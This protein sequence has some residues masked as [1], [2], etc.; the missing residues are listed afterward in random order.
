[1]AHVHSVVRAGFRYAVPLGPCRGWGRPEA[2]HLLEGLIE[3]A[4]REMKIDPIAL[5]RRNLVAPG[6]MPYRTASGQ[7]MDCG[8][9][10][11]M[12]ER[13]LE[14]A[15]WDG[16]PKRR[17]ESERRGLR[18]GIGLAMHCGYSGLQAERMELRVDPNGSVS[19][20]VGT[21]STGQGH[22]TMYAQMVCEWLG[23]PL[24]SVRVF[25][26]DTDRVLFGR[27]TYAERSAIVGGSALKGAADEVIRK[28][29]RLAAWML[30]ANDADIEFKHGE[31]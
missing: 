6:A 24:E 8:D 15:E 13:N 1:R 25:Q 20:H 17:A 29:K 28:G 7:V 9:F 3:R 31:F 30:E 10:A 5:R 26:G 11:R 23:V 22:E 14:I 21:M 16:F 27:G 18:R 19:A 12:L 2:I 4:A